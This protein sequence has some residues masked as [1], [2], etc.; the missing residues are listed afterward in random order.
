MSQ[1]SYLRH[2]RPGKSGIARQAITHAEGLQGEFE[3]R[4]AWPVNR[5]IEAEP[6]V[7]QARKGMERRKR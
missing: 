7:E 1:E 3:S 6:A 4:H 2:S 5:N